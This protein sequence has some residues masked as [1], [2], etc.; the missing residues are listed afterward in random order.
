[1]QLRTAYT[2][3]TS[4]DESNPAQVQIFFVGWILNCNYD[5]ERG[6][7]KHE[8]NPTREEIIAPARFDSCLF[9]GFFVLAVQ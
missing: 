4:N 2:D 9:F 5:R 7:K 3:Q 6:L 1:M 8:S